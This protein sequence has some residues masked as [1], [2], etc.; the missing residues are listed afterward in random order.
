MLASGVEDRA[1]PPAGRGRVV[2]P[3]LPHALPRSLTAAERAHDGG[4]RKSQYSTLISPPY[5]FSCLI[6][7]GVGGAGLE[8][9]LRIHDRRFGN[10]FVDIRQRVLCDLLYF[11]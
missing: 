8:S 2:E 5:T 9:G 11:G 1:K 3:S 7:S 10:R 4:K 6:T